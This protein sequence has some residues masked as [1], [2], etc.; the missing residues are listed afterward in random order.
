M[1][2]DAMEIQASFDAAQYFF[3]I[4][5]AKKRNE[6]MSNYQLRQFKDQTAPLVRIL[7]IL[8]EAL[9]DAILVGEWIED[10]L[11]PPSPGD[12]PKRLRDALVSPLGL[13]ILGFVGR[14]RRFSKLTSIM[15]I[16][17]FLFSNKK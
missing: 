2:Y 7:M 10:G 6:I 13:M 11:D 4:L 8:T 14:R 1:G 16:W 15:N 9:G 5:M 3:Y 17:S 12:L